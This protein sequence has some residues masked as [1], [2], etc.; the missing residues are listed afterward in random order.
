MSQV[1]LVLGGLPGITLFVFDMTRN[2]ILSSLGVFM[3]SHTQWW[4]STIFIVQW[5]YAW[6]LWMISLRR[7]AWLPSSVAFFA[8]AT[9][10][11]A[12]EWPIGVVWVTSGMRLRVIIIRTVECNL[13]SL[14][15][16]ILKMVLISVKSDIPVY[17]WTDRKLTAVRDLNRRPAQAEL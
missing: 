17:Y 13:W 1:N 14:F 11:L 7:N 12:S 15:S 6:R 10:Y 16:Q 5:V 9:Y 8:M 4:F 3:G 2:H